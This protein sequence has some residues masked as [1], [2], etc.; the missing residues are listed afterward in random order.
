MPVWARPRATSLSG[1]CFDARGSI[2][3]GNL[4]PFERKHSTQRQEPRDIR[5]YHGQQSTLSSARPCNVEAKYTTAF[6][7][8]RQHTHRSSSIA[9]LLAVHWAVV[10]DSADVPGN[11]H[12]H[13][14]CCTGVPSRT[15][16][17][18]SIVRSDT[19]TVGEHVVGAC[20]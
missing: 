18:R 17:S 5:G 1:K 13:H 20:Q 9:G 16:T 12:S 7:R 10:P 14:Q 6:T 3:A 8:H 19:D 15:T 11:I 2:S 4:S